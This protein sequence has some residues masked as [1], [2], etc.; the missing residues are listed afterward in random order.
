MLIKQLGAENGIGETILRDIKTTGEY[1]KKQR[2][3][4]HIKKKIR[5]KQK[6]RGSDDFDKFLKNQFFHRL[7][8]D[9]T[10][11]NRLREVSAR[12]QGQ[13]KTNSKEV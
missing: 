3:G 13:G 7:A 6:I 1:I 11:W 10:E 4:D 8:T 12:K 5:G 9:R 2:S